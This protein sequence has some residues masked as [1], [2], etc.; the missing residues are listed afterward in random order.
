[1]NWFISGQDLSDV[2]L[3]A[4]HPDH[5]LK[6]LTAL[7]VGSLIQAVLQEG[8]GDFNQ[9][10]KHNAS[11]HNGQCLFGYGKIIFFF[12]QLNYTCNECCALP[13]SEYNSKRKLLT[14]ALQIE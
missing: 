4:S 10:L 5:Q 1:M 11:T 9:W 3:Y 2:L 12:L 8:R 7:A 14:L 6:G 13:L